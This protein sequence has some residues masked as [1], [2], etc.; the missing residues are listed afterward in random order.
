MAKK[1]TY[2]QLK[3]IIESTFQEYSDVNYKEKYSVVN[4]GFP[5][6]FNLSLNEPELLDTF[7]D[8][9][10]YDKSL[11]FAKI[12]PVIRSNDFEQ[13]ILSKT[14]IK[15]LGLFEMAGI[16]L[17]DTKSTNLATN[18]QRVINWIWKLLIDKLNFD[19]SKIYVKLSS[20]GTI[21]K[22]TK[23]KYKINKDIDKDELSYNY[24]KELGVP[25]KNFIWDNTRDTFLSLFMFSRPTPWGYRNEILYDIG[26]GNKEENLLDIGTI[27]Y[28]PWKPIF[29]SDGQKKKDYM[30]KEIQPWENSIAIAGVGVERLLIV[31]N[32]FKNSVEC[33]HI[34]PLFSKVL[35]DSRNKDQKVSFIL[36]ETIRVLHRVLTDSAGYVNLSSNRKLVLSIYINELYN[37]LKLLGI[38]LKNIKKYLKINSNL[39][40]N[41]LEL[42]NYDFIAREISYAFERRFE[43]SPAFPRAEY[44]DG[45]EG[46]KKVANEI[47]REKGTP[48]DVFFSS[49]LTK[50]VPFYSKYFRKTRIE[51]NIPLR[52]LSDESKKIEKTKKK[53]KEEL[54][55]IRYAKG[56]TKGIN[57]AVYIF[58]NKLAVITATERE[59]GGIIIENK[60]LSEIMKRLFEKYWTSAKK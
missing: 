43:E 28:F 8:Y 25:E 35:K 19:P 58:H 53:D 55:K 15:H 33:S 40:Q 49:K 14:S 48:V 7:G 27:E 1:I 39:Q 9:L 51:R 4:D 34:F 45:T 2:P 3:K 16:S 57:S 13:K 6:N 36:T 31:L 59:R 56:I 22:L 37:S 42:R 21:E 52:V 10:N 29:V 38:P 46:L 17:A 41:Y 32:N 30:I 11:F 24:W 50:A 23:G 26:E 5:G 12:Q 20:G 60:E 54:R 18:T 47:L 44:Y